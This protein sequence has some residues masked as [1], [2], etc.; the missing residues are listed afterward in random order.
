VAWLRKAKAFANV[1]SCAP[2]MRNAMEVSMCISQVKS[3]GRDDCQGEL[4]G[5]LAR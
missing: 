1:N 3:S 5:A 2:D 4:Q